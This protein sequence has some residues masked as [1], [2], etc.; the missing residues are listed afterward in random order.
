VTF[1]L[2]LLSR[3]LPAAPDIFGRARGRI[4]AGWLTMVSSWLRRPERSGSKC[5]QGRTYS[6]AISASARRCFAGKSIDQRSATLVQKAAKHCASDRTCEANKVHQRQSNHGDGRSTASLLPLELPPAPPLPWRSGTPPKTSS[7]T[8]LRS[9]RT[10]P[11]P[12]GNMRS[13]SPPSRAD[14]PS[15]TLSSF[16]STPSITLCRSTGVITSR[17][18]RHP[19]ARVSSSRLPYFS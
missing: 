6:S 7:I 1:G 10:S 18:S 13:I 5:A 12:P 11:A 3:S 16:L 15:L 19:T 14:R 4:G 8:T 2:L 9:L 17:A